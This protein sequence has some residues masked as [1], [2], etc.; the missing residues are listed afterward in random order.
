MTIL[1][2]GR[3]NDRIVRSEIIIEKI[4]FKGETNDRQRIKKVWNIPKIITND[5]G[6]QLM[7]G[8]DPP[9]STPN[10]SEGL[11]EYFLD[12]KY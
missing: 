6:F 8:F 12:N 2:K 4:K 1:E 10:K 3:K 5:I 9:T 11:K 7:F